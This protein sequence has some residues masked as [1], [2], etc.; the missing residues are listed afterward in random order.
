MIRRDRG[1]IVALVALV[2]LGTGCVGPSRAHK[3]E[4]NQRISARDWSGAVAQV[5]AAK[6]SEYGEN[7]SVLYYLDK[8]VLLHDAGQFAESDALLDQAELRM[9]ELYTRSISKGAASFLVNDN[10]EAYAGQVHERTL[11]HLVRALNYAYLDNTESAVVEA[12]KVTAFL[13]ELN[14][15]LGDEAL[16]YR[17]DAFAQYLAGLLFEDRGMVDDA[18]ISFQAARD[19]YQVYREAF[20]VNPPELDP[21]D[22]FPADGELVFLH[23]NGTAPRRETRTIQIA[24]NDAMIALN[25][26]GEAEENSQ[27]KN[28]MVAGIAGNAITVALPEFVQDPYDIAESEVEAAGVRARTVLLQDVT[29]LARKNL[30]AVLPSIQTKALVRATVKFLIAKLAEE[31]TKRQVGEGFGLLVGLV[32]RV[33]AAA[34]ETA[35]TRCWSTL[36]A[37]FRMARLRLPAGTHSVAVQYYAAGGAPVGSEVLENVEIRQGRRTYVHVR[38]GSSFQAV[39]QPA[40]AAPAAAPEPPPAPAP[41]P[42]VALH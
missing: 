38:T 18:R 37:E 6:E 19:A 9:D 28:A 30:E 42:A 29:A 4:L 3:L 2:A 13:A 41:E 12:R 14:G 35:D 7:N 11:L 1:W 21:G 33:A 36:P 23:Y 34:S 10:S 40:P 25:E 27:V 17:D 8:A 22:G 32:G 20:G 26:S 31:E 5:D 39:P 24:W 16:P 15:Q